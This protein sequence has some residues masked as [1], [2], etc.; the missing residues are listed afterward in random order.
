M[1]KHNKHLINLLK[2]FPDQNPNPV[3][4][5][6][7]DGILEYFNNPSKD[8]INYYNFK[9]KNKISDIFLHHLK[10]T[11][12]KSEHSFEIKLE[13]SSFYFKAVYI[14]ELKSVNIYGTDIT[15]KKVIDKFPDSNPNPV[16][17][18]DS[19]GKL[20]YFNKA[21]TYIIKQLEVD[22]NIKMPIQILDKI[23]NGKE[24][25]E[26]KIGSKVYLFNIVKINEFNFFLMYGTDITDT[27]DKEEILKKLSKYFS[28]QVYNSIF[29]GQLDVTINTSRKDLTVFFSDIKSFT[30]ITEKLEPEVL[31]KLITNY[32]TAMTDIAIEYGGTVDKYIGDAIM[33]FFGDPNSNGKKDDAIACVSMALKMKKALTS[34]RK[35]WKLTGL[36]ESLNVRMGIHTDVCTV[37]NFGSLDRLDYTVLGNGVNLASRLESLANSNEI[38]ISENTYNLVKKDIECNYFDEIKVKGKS[39]SIKTFQVVGN[40]NKKMKKTKIETSKD[41]FKLKIDKEKIK[42]ID[43]VVS[44]LEDSIEKLTN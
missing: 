36:S 39:H 38:L 34:L 23:F 2:K 25:F 15:A 11:I 31:T 42:N 35:S 14:E 16:I 1:S 10:E 8:I 33:I 26:L 17:R 43:E 41:G 6:S 7:I 3:I 21:S 28:P 13:H 9:L 19:K 32:L 4:R 37:G 22:L 40:K 12:S 27:K 44:F 24:I 5:L 18:I 20:S 29:S 30:T